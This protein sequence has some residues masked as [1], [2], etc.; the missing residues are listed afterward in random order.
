[1]VFARAGGTQG[2]G[3]VCCYGAPNFE[4]TSF[5]GKRYQ[6]MNGG[7]FTN[8]TKAQLDA[9]PGSVDGEILGVEVSEKAIVP[10]QTAGVGQ[11][12][13]LDSP[14]PVAGQPG[15]LPAGG[16]WAYVAFRVDSAGAMDLGGGLGNLHAGVGAGGDPVGVGASGL[17]FTGFAWRIA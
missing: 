7:K 11:W 12:R 9:W 3:Y 5:I 10:I 1:M 16:T 15:Y 8:R 13:K 2:P 14:T 4:G 17:R 6:I